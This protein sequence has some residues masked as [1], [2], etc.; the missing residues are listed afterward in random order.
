MLKY[1]MKD[2]TT[3]AQRRGVAAATVD[4]YDEEVKLKDNPEH[5]K[6]NPNAVKCKAQRESKKAVDEAAASKERSRGVAGF[7]IAS[8]LASLH[9]L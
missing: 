3:S 6:H 4:G 8:I 5:F 7:V 9:Y 1:F 2:A